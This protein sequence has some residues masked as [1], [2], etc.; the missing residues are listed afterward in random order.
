[1]PGFVDSCPARVNNGSNWLPHCEAI[2]SIDLGTASGEK[3]AAEGNC[4]GVL[5]MHRNK[6]LVVVS[7]FQLT[8]VKV[9]NK[10]VPQ[11]VFAMNKTTKKTR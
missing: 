11:F 5:G 10:F 3:V 4:L 8:H 9:N 1:M 7:I 2:V 6:I